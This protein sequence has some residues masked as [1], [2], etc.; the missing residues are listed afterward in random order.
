MVKL[1][2]PDIDIEF[3]RQFGGPIFASAVR[4]DYAYVGIGPRLVILNVANPAHPVVVGQHFL[5]GPVNDVDLAGRVC[6][7]DYASCTLMM[8][9][10]QVCVLSI[11]ADPANP[12]EIGSVTTIRLEWAFCEN[13]RSCGR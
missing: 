12:T 9:Y 13:V 2:R 1:P 3:V 5:P 8:S 10:I 7:C 4:G 6:L 11:L